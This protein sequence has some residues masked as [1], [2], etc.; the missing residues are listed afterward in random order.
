MKH[1]RMTRDKWIQIIFP[2]YF[3]VFF[4][5]CFIGSRSDTPSP[6]L[7]TIAIVMAL[8]IAIGGLIFFF[9]SIIT[10]DDDS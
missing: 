6:V 3:A 5:V 7:V 9:Y 8:P 2:I 4:M 1:I 10:T